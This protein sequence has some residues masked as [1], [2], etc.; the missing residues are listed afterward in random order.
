MTVLEL[1]ELIGKNTATIPGGA[2]ATRDGKDE[3]SF[4][5]PVMVTAEYATMILLTGDVVIEHKDQPEVPG[6]FAVNDLIFNQF[7]EAVRLMEAGHNDHTVLASLPHSIYVMLI[8]EEVSD[9]EPENVLDRDIETATDIIEKLR[10]A[11]V[12]DKTL[13]GLIPE[14]I[15]R[16]ME[17]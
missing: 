11:G 12:D 8:T 4:S 16:E 3:G 15:L 13:K 2:V 14:Y 6:K 7:R 17:E 1:S 9:L 5:T 10:T